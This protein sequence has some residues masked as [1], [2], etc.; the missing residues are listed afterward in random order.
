[1]SRFIPLVCLTMCLVVAPAVAEEPGVRHD[2]SDVERW[3][4]VFDDPARDE[5]QKPLELLTYFGL[6]AGETVADLGAGTGYFTKLLSVA[7]GPEGRVYAVDVEQAM[8]DHLMDR[9]D[10]MTER[11]TPVLAAP[12]DPRLPEGEVDLVVTVNTWHH[13]AKRKKYLR[14]L[15]KSLTPEGRLVIID[16][17]EGELPLGPPAGHKLGR[18]QVVDELDDADWRLVAE[19]V[20]LPYQYVLTFLPPAKRDTRR[21]VGR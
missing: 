4:R 13:I 7:V 6:D 21:F 19:S 20:A 12:D 3:S 5:W 2:W 14:R 15:A 11:V 9:D 18:E 16:W 10:V 17:H 1:M 8:L